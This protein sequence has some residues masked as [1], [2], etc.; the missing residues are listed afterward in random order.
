M[1][2]E[3]Q[4]SFRYLPITPRTMR[5]GLYLTGCG[6]LCVP[7]HGPHPPR[8]HPNLY[9]FTWDRGRVLPE[10]Q[11]VYLL[12]GKGT[13]ES[14]PSGRRTI[15]AGDLFFYSLVYGTAIGPP[16]TR[17]GKPAGLASTAATWAR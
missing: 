7:A 2:N 17:A 3:F 14:A 1:C 10:Y 13:F 16:E 4:D 15:A 9:Q 8:D 6:H 12:Q 11:A 5:W